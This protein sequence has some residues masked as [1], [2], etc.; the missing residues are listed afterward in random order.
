VTKPARTTRRKESA[1]ADSS[2]DLPRDIRV[3]DVVRHAR[4]QGDYTGTVTD[5]DDSD[6]QISV[7]VD[8]HGSCVNNQLDPEDLILITDPEEIIAALQNPPRPLEMY[9]PIWP[10]TPTDDAN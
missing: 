2:R 5:V 10:M 4:W 8:W 7:F 1:V 3:G 6:G 9:G